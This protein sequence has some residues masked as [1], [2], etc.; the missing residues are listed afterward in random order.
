MV[1]IAGL[2]SSVV[3]AKPLLRPE[4]RLWPPA[5]LSGVCARGHKLKTALLPD[6]LWARIYRSE[7]EGLDR[8]GRGENGLYRAGITPGE[9]IL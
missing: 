4:T 2:L 9:R 5:A 8:S 1:V 6:V 3:C 7:G